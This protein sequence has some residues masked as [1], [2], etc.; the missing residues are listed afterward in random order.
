MDEAQPQPL[1]RNPTEIRKRLR[2]L[3]N[4]ALDD[5]GYLHLDDAPPRANV[6]GQAPED[7]PV[8]PDFNPPPSPPHD[9]AEHFRADDDNAQEEEHDRLGRL[10]DELRE[11]ALPVPDPQRA[12]PEPADEEKF[13]DAD[14]ANDDNSGEEEEDDDPGNET[15]PWADAQSTP[16]PKRGLVPPARPTGA[17]AKTPKSPMKPASG[18]GKMFTKSPFL[19]AAGSQI[20]RLTRRQDGKEAEMIPK[21][22]EGPE[23]TARRLLREKKLADAAASASKANLARSRQ[24]AVRRRAQ[25]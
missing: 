25:E 24:D 2:K 21:W 15:L 18:R 12:R 9:D 8:N 14:L 6:F 4:D 16:S 23:Q 1:Q 17:R 3:N 10:A 13:H 22:G 11:G 20:S 7:P 5:E 19:K